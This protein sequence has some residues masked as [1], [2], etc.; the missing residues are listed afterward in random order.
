VGEEGVRR[1]STD[2]IH[3]IMAPLPYVLH[4]S[5]KAGPLTVDY[6]Q[7]QEKGLKGGVGTG[8]VLGGWLAAFFA[9][10]RLLFALLSARRSSPWFVSLGG[11]RSLFLRL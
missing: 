9:L 6:A 3:W 8:L 2:I 11:L 5:Q 7:S 4:T 1:N 10:G